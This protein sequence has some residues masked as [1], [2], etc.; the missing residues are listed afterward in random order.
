[1]LGTVLFFMVL[2]SCFALS[3]DILVTFLDGILP[4]S[5]Q[6]FLFAAKAVGR[7][8]G[9]WPMWPLWSVGSARE[10]GSGVGCDHH[11]E[12]ADTC[13]AKSRHPST[14]RG[15]EVPVHL[16]FTVLLSASWCA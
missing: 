14:Y 5:E 16:L 7:S 10:G 2:Q 9:L 13:T 6:P 12:G 15:P 4:G 8:A 11:S 1:M 3:C